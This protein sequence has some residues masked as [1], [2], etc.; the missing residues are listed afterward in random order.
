MLF[1]ELNTKSIVFWIVSEKFSAEDFSKRI[2]SDQEVY[3][4]NV[5]QFVE[6]LVKWTWISKVIDKNRDVRKVRE[7]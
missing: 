2:D 5:R 7:Y 6:V 3:W 1:Y 4:R